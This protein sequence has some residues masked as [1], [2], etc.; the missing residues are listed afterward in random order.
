MDVLLL[1][2][3]RDG[4]EEAT[5]LAV[6]KE[7]PGTSSA[8]SC[9]TLVWRTTS[10]AWGDKLRLSILLGTN[11]LKSD[12]ISKELLKLNRNKKHL[13]AKRNT[14]LDKIWIE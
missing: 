6:E 11:Y 7:P 8:R 4:V 5:L 1:P 14:E 13:K 9:A 12:E 3:F 2:P 10:R